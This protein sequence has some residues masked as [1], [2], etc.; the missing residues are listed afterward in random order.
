MYKKNFCVVIP[1]FN[2]ALHIC[3]VINKL[4]KQDIYVIVINDGSTDNTNELLS[5]YKKNFWLITHKTNKG[6]GEAIKAGFNVAIK[7]N[8]DYI[9]T[10][11][12]D[13]QHDSYEIPFFIEKILNSNNDL[14]IGNR[15]F[16]TNNMPITRIF[17]NKIASI[18]VSKISKQYIP[19]ALNGYRLIK[20]TVL[21]NINLKN[22]RFDIVPEILIKA[23]K[24]GF[25]IGYV[26]VK[27]IY[28]NEISHIQPLRDGFMFFKYIF[29]CLQRD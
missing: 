28:G 17:A 15:M 23:S 25:K 10:L 27:T 5:K 3:S 18:I 11:D 12:G 9:I 14:I 22:K 2:E 8:F 7:K 26:N 16:N 20:R 6:K 24:K 29:S 13:G 19:D 1:I 21:E 4:Q